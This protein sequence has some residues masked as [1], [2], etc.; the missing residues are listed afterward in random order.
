MLMIAAVVLIAQDPTSVEGPLS[1]LNV[2][3]GVWQSC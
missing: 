3:V 1:L 2:L